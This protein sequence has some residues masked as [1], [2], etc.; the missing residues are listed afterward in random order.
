[1]STHTRTATLFAVEASTTDERV[2]VNASVWFVDNDG[3]RVVFHRHEPIYRVALEDQVHLRLVAIMLRQSRL[4]TQEEICRAFRHSVSTQARWER[5]YC[6]HGIDGLIPRKRPGRSRSLDRGQETFVRKWF[7]EGC[8]NREMARQ[9]GVDEVTI[10][11][12]LKRRGLSRKPVERA[13]MLPGIEAEDSAAV[14]AIASAL[15]SAAKSTGET[16]TETLA[17]LEAAPE[18]LSETAPAASPA[19]LQPTTTSS[20]TLDHDPHDRSGDRALARL[21]LLDDAVPLFADAECVPRAGVLLAVPLL[22]GHELIEAFAK[23]YG[24]LHPSFYGLRTIVVT[25][26][27]AALL[28]IKRPEH[29]KEYRPEDLGAILG[30]DRAPE[31]KTVRRKFASLAAMQRASEL[32]EEVARRRISRSEDCVAFLYIDGHV[33]E[34]HGKHPLFQAK[35]A[36]RQVV[37]PAVTDNWVHGADGE[38]LLVVTSEVNAKLTQVLEPILADVRRLVGDERRMTAVFDRGGFSPKLFARLI[39]AG[40]DVITYR[41]GNARKLPAAQ[42]VVQKEIID[43]AS[44][45]YTICDR[46]RVRIGKLPSGKKQGGK[47]GKTKNAYLWMREVRVLRHDG[48]QTSILTNRQDLSAVTVAYRIFYR[49]CQE[50]FFKYM[51]EEFALDALIEY[52]A[53]DLPDTTDCRN[54]KWLRITRQI[55]EARAEV[56][57]LQI[58]LGKKV[59]ANQEA[60]RRTMRGFKIAQARLRKQL[61]RAEAKVERLL[62]QRKKIPRRVPATDRVML[63]TEQKLIADTIKMVAYQVETQLLGMLQGNYAR[64]DEE[65][66]TLL[67]AA[68]QSSASL[69]VVDNELRVTI[70]PQSSPHRTAALSALCAQLDA[71]AIPFPGTQLRLRLAV[72]AAEPVT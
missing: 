38:P 15:P 8:S 46:P 43:G 5:D 63:K 44:R 34:Y 35:K 19:A 42:F 30:L 52:G 50:N 29:F 20:F 12:T 54:P 23:V 16:A 53:E 68:F 1:M 3:Y 64:V 62:R 51:D 32:M 9:L 55:A 36:Q 37:T 56:K 17:R 33:R 25:L 24:S 66:R 7:H 60:N 18:C 67:H 61:R 41:K 58:E 48:R 59:E 71:L 39:D 47:R 31:V 28:R 14:E 49:W 26:F 45:E 72:Q 21:G 69:E 65:G 2:F 10:R 13:A 57:P 70:A 11:R 6:E 40:F 22:V 4:A 27:L